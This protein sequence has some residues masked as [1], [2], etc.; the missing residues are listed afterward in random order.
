MTPDFARAVDP[1]FLTIIDLVDRLEKGEAMAF[2]HVRTKVNNIL[3]TTD[4][5]LGGKGDLAKLTIY[6]LVCWIDE[7]L[8]NTQ[9]M[10][11]TQWLNRTLEFERY[12]RSE[13]YTKFY[14][15]ALY[16]MQAAQYR[17]ALEVYYLCVVLGFQ[18]MYRANE[19]G[20]LSDP[21]SLGFDPSFP[22]NLEAWLK[23]VAQSLVLKSAREQLESGEQGETGHQP[24]FGQQRLMGAV[25]L[26]VIF[27]AI[28]SIVI[29]VLFV[30]P[31]RT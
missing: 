15:S 13:A 6:A 17:D 18:G 8:I 27:A 1:S 12:Q 2:D 31:H 5:L 25:M 10:G 23:W 24:L 19:A 14:Q 16:A 30:L 29:P 21:A 22:K 20:T 9:W 28:L 3:N 4:S 11:R 7:L 26:F